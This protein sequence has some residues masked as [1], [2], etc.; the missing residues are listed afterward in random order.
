MSFVHRSPLLRGLTSWWWPILEESKII[1][2]NQMADIDTLLEAKTTLL[3]HEGFLN[4]LVE[5]LGGTVDW[6][7][8][9]TVHSCRLRHLE[10]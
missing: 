3:Y 1:P 7:N 2:V 8:S 9:C 10:M 6:I 5:E 4:E